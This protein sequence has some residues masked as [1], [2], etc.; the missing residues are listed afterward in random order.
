M[1]TA[2]MGFLVRWSLEI[3]AKSNNRWWREREAFT[4][5]KNKSTLGL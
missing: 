4:H 2:V 1:K 3:K 5:F